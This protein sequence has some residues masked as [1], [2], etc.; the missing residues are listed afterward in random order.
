M[1]SVTA[2]LAIG[3]STDKDGERKPAPVTFNIEGAE[4]GKEQGTA[5]AA[6]TTAPAQLVCHAGGACC[7]CGYQLSCKTMRCAYR[8]AGRNC[9]SCWCLVRCANVAPQTRQ[10][11]QLRPDRR[12]AHRV[13]L[14][15]N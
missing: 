11:E 10:D 5:P 13:V 2:P 6:N 3:G 15:D 14:Q 9:V 12:Q 1:T 7:K 4:R 8:R